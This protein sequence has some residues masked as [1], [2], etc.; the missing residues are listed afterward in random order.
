MPIQHT[1]VFRLRH[2]PGSRE[3]H[4]FLA[5]ARTALTSIPGVEDF[6]FAE[7]PEPVSSRFVGDARLRRL[8]ADAGGDIARAHE[9]F[10]WNVLAS[11]A[12]K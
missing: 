7:F 2:Q 10:E 8:L 1:V 3:E 11:G 4:A 9:L 6:E 12:A 5:D